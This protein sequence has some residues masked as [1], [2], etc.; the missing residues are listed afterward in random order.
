MPPARGKTATLAPFFK[1]YLF[2]INILRRANG[3]AVAVCSGGA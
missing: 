3:N 2:K 1:N